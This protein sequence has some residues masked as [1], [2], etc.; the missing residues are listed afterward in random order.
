M[1]KL[2]GIIGGMG[3]MASQL[4]YK[5]VTDMTEAS[6]DQ[7]HLNMIIYSDASMQDRTSAILNGDY[8]K[9]HNQLLADAKILEK[10][11]CEAIGVTCNTLPCGLRRI[12]PGCNKGLQSK[13][14]SRKSCAVPS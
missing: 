9:I 8:A 3:P 2:I 6:C 5:M 4:F 11:G 13:A 10:S 14:K 1:S 7:D 12:P